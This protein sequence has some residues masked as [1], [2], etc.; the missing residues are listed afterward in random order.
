[1]NKLKLK[2]EIYKYVMLIQQ[3]VRMMKLTINVFHYS[4]LRI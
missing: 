2:R 1:M 4:A 3:K